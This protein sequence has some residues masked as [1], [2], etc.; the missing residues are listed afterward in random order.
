MLSFDDLPVP[1]KCW[2]TPASLPSVCTGFFWS[3]LSLLILCEMPHNSF[4]FCIISVRLILPIIALS[5]Y[6]IFSHKVPEMMGLSGFCPIKPENN[7]K[8]TH[9]QGHKYKTNLHTAQM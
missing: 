2:V 3:E 1:K 8:I 4:C 5:N 7:E 6:K 9:T